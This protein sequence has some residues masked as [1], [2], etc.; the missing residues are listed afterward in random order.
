MSPFVPSPA[1][2]VNQDVVL[3]HGTLKGH[4]QSILAGVNVAL[5]R[6]HTDFGRGFYTTTVEQQARSWAWQLSQQ[7]IGSAPAVIRF[8][9]SRD[10]LAR[11]DFLFF[12]RGSFDAEDYWSFVHH[13]RSVALHHGRKP[14][15]V[16][17]DLVAGPVA[18]TWRTRLAIYDADQV[19]FHTP[20][21]A[22]VLDKSNKGELP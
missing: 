18:A 7:I 16:W 8:D 19:S 14:R 4:V 10:E 3:Y 21:A 5:G 20:K 15:K 13:C 11:L 1:R 6:R 22:A 2:W 12:I 9:V 17:Y